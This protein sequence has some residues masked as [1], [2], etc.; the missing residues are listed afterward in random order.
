MAMKT[1][2]VINLT[3]HKVLAIAYKIQYIVSSSYI[4]CIYTVY[5]Q[6]TDCND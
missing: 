4:L 2:P 3:Q 6:C 5:T 1:N